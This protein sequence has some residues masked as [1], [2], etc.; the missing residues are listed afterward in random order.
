MIDLLTGKLR[1]NAAVEAGQILV[2]GGEEKLYE[3]M[4]FFR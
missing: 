3:I 1:A 4:S 2:D